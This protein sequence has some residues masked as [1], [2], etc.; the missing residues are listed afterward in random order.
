MDIEFNPYDD[1]KFSGSKL[2]YEAICYEAEISIDV[3]LS[4]P[5]LAQNKSGV[6]PHHKALVVD[7]TKFLLLYVEKEK[8]RT[9]LGDARR[10]VRQVTRVEGC[11]DWKYPLR[12]PMVGIDVLETPLEEKD[13]EG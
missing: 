1:G 12:L 6:F 10:R 2:M 11:L 9:N 5:W 4:Y 3:I 8:A 7:D 13:F